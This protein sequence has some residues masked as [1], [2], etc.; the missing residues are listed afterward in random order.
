MKSI[1]NGVIVIG[2]IA[3]IMLLFVAVG[4]QKRVAAP[5][6]EEAET[7]SAKAAKQVKPEKVSKLYDFE[8]KPLHTVEQCAQCHI[9][10]F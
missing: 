10:V 5:T 1:R 8:P 6:V 3:I 7:I 2:A 9:S 4:C